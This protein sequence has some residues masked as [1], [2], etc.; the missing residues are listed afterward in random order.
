MAEHALEDLDPSFVQEVQ[1][2]DII[3][4]GN[5]WGCGSSRE[6]AV[7]CLK[8]NGIGAIVAKSFGR[9]H[10]RN[11]LNAA[12]PAIICSSAVEAA[13]PG[14]RML[15][16]LESG[17]IQIQEQ[18][19]TFP[20]LPNEIM[21]IFKAGGLVSYTRMQLQTPKGYTAASSFSP[22]RTNSENSWNT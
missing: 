2:G 10:Y 22:L 17:K 16:D 1:P 21:D 7:T 4:A 9:I 19:F 8:E 5:N 3:V 6:Q 20:P 14:G 15:I 13:E 18:T 12:L 11:C